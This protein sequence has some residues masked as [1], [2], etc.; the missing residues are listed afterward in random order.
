MALTPG[1]LT[2]MLDVAW[3]VTLVLAVAWGAT[4][5]LGRRPAAVAPRGVGLGV[6]GRAG[7]ADAGRRPAVVADRRAAGLRCVGHR[8]LV[9]QR[10][11]VTAATAAAHHTRRAGVD[12]A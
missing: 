7:R 8:A 2:V 9:P 12:G 11:P 3:R 4:R 1:T 5:L 6:A 10:P